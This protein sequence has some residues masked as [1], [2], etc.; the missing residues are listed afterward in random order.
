MVCI[1]NIDGLMYLFLFYL[2]NVFWGVWLSINSVVFIGKEYCNFD[3][4]IKDNDS[5]LF[6]ECIDVNMDGFDVRNLFLDL[7]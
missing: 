2:N 5:L 7:L 4:N 1:E 6:L 3:F